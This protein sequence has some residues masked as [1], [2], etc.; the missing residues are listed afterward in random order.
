M[1]ETAGSGNSSTGEKS[2]YII[3]MII[4]IWLKYFRLT[5]SQTG[6]SD[7]D[8]LIVWFNG[9][10]GSSDLSTKDQRTFQ[11]VVLLEVCS[12]NLVLFMLMLMERHCTKTFLLGIRYLTNL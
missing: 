5:E 10:P 11:D 2:F 1:Q 9:G 3:L 8:P 6:S 4:K 12:R 7:D